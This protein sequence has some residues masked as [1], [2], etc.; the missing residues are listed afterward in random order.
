MN[1]EEFLC[2]LRAI[3]REITCMSPTRFAERFKNSTINF[4]HYSWGKDRVKLHV[5]ISMKK[6][7]LD[8]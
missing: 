8:E 5:S 1:R 6:I 2:K 4:E 3:V 7:K